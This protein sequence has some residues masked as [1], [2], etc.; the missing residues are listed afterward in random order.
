MVLHYY[1]TLYRPGYTT[2]YGYMTSLA[3]RTDEEIDTELKESM[4]YHASDKS[5]ENGQRVLCGCY[6]K[7]SP[8]IPNDFTPYG[9]TSQSFDRCRQVFRSPIR[10]AKTVENPYE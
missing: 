7:N 4:I 8:S 5:E 9:S 2:S 3:V 6:I 10:Q 1:S